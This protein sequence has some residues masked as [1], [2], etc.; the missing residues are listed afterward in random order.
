MLF[1]DTL[2]NDGRL[3][4][5]VVVGLWALFLG[6]TTILTRGVKIQIADAGKRVY[7]PGQLGTR[8]AIVAFFAFFVFGSYEVVYLRTEW[9]VVLFMVT[10]AAGLGCAV[11]EWF[12]ARKERRAQDRKKSHA[13]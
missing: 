10:A 7:R 13:R 5:M 1:T 9:R 8:W 4:N 11:M 6:M 12:Y 2:S 3:I